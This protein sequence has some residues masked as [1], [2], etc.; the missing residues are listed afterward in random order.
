[1]HTLNCA[2]RIAQY[3]TDIG[4]RRSSAGGYDLRVRENVEHLEELRARAEDAGL[5]TATVPL[6][7]K[8]TVRCMET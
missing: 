6:N 3:A 4:R 7:R 5:T 1:M 2:S 8:S